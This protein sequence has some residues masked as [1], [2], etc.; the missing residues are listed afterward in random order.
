[1][2]ELEREKRRTDSHR[3]EKSIRSHACI[4]RQLLRWDCEVLRGGKLIRNYLLRVRPRK[5]YIQEATSFY[6]AEFRA[7]LPSFYYRGSKRGWTIVL[8]PT[9]LPPEE[10]RHERNDL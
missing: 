10:D 9:Y 3:E 1:M 4:T 8:L 7:G 2:R 6:I 5:V